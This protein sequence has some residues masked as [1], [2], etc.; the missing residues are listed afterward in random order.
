MELNDKIAEWAAKLWSEVYV[1][2]VGKGSTTNHC[3][4]E[5]DTAVAEFTKRF[6]V[7]ENG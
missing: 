7:K 6:T 5:A 4:Q 3:L 1:L 2:H